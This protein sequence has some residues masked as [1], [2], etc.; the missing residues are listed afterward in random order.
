M[1][2]ELLIGVGVGSVVVW[3]VVRGVVYLRCRVTGDLP[4]RSFTES[5][6]EEQEMRGVEVRVDCGKGSASCLPGVGRV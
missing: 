6:A 4:G 3:G 5:W 1:L 2:A